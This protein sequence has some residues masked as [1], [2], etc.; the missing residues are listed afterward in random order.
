MQ[1]N[2]KKVKV[3]QLTGGFR[4]KID[5]QPISGGVASFLKNY[6][7]KMDL[8]RIHF[9]FMAIRN[10]SFEL[11]RKEFEALGSRLYTLDIQTDG[12]HR[13]FTTI[14]RLSKFL[15]NNQYDA[16][17]I[18]IGSFFPVL[19]CAIAARI[20]GVK[21]IIAHSHSSGKNSRRKRILINIFAPMLSIFANRYC[22]CSLVAAE[23]LFSRGIIRKKKYHIIKNAIDIE[24]FTFDENLRNEMR[25]NLGYSNELVIGHVGR[26]VEVKN[27]NFLIDF[28]AEFNKRIPNSR[29][30]L[31]GDG[32]LK[33]KIEEK[34]S[35]LGLS[36][37]VKFM[38]QQ[39]NIHR[40]YQAMDLF[41][42]P[43]LLE[44][45]PIVA[46]EA[47]STGLPCYVSS[48][49]TDEINVTNLCKFFS[50]EDGPESLAEMVS[51]DLKKFGER[52][53]ASQ[54]IIDAGYSLEDNLSVFENLYFR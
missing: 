46:L 17:H 38:G 20:A 10:Q 52:K 25:A 8:S 44:G 5:G 36:E 45:F 29:L 18:N 28:F 22:A 37:Y 53:D 4:K 21:I 26:F 41:V 24:K 3:L 1:S 32:E 50:L 30:L 34:V 48:N 9:D 51:R 35:V 39:K 6:Y 40:Y 16:V 27:H 31:L 43:S 33:S 11:Y 49:I 54:Q 23:N 12:F 14:H 19:T 47:Q 15:K 42:M 7:T 13:F 2:G